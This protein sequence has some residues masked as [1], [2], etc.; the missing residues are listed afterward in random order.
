MS[1]DVKQLGLGERLRHYREKA[2]LS[3]DA[4]AQKVGLS[5]ESVA[6]IEAGHQVPDLKQLV[7]LAE[8]VAAPLPALFT[9]AS[10]VSR[11]EF[12]RAADRWKVQPSTDHATAANYRYEALS[13]RLTEKLMS[14][15]LIEMSPHHPGELPLSAHEGEEFLFLL[16]GEA[17]V[18]IEE[19]KYTMRAGDSLYFDSRLNH[20]IRPSGAQPAR[21]IA[22]LAQDHKQPPVNPFD[23][24]YV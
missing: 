5:A 11:V 9:P 13:Y 3:V 4:V 15:F 8:A 2:G 19:H 16:S 10:V 1:T 12:V 7:T 6:G 18:T 17:I 20:S 24:A 22:C 14:P 23:R 21:L